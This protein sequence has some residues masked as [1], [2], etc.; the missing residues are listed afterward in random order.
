MLEI[1]AV[2][3]VIENEISLGMTQKQIAET[4]AMAIVV[5]SYKPDWPRINKAISDKWPKGLLRVKTM[6]WKIV[7]E[8]Q[9]EARRALA[10]LN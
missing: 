9:R 5:Q 2:E 1:A 4:Y 8:R 7:E 10:E 3:W 6:A